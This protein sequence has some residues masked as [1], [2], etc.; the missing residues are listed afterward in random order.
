MI[1]DLVGGC[2][3]INLRMDGVNCVLEGGYCGG[4][5]RCLFLRIVVIIC[6]VFAV[7]KFEFVIN[8]VVSKRVVESAK[9]AIEFGF[10]VVL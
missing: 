5:S 4:V 9:M 2:C 10:T 3:R 1:I 7:Y 8:D 6:S